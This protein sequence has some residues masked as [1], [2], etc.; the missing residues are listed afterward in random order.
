MSTRRFGKDT[1]REGMEEENAGR[2]QKNFSL[3]LGHSS[4][5]ETQGNLTVSVWSLNF[6]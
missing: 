6:T 2:G 1:T 5:L 4:S 3:R